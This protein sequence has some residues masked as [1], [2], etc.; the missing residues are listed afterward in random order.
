[1]RLTGL[2]VRGFRN[3]AALEL[4]FPAEGV[5]VVGG[6]GQGKTNLLEAIYYLMLFRS[7]RGAKDRELVRFGEAGFWVAGVAAQEGS[8]EREVG[9]RYELATGRKT[10]V[11]DGMAVEKLADAAGQ[12]LAVPFGPADGEIVFGTPG[13]RRRFLDVVLSVSQPGYLGRLVQMR[14]ALKQRNAALRRGRRDEAR[15]F[16]APLVEAAAFVARCRRSWVEDWAD[17]FGELCAALGEP[18]AADLRYVTQVEESGS[19]AAWRR[20]L[21]KHLDR[22]LRRGA[23]TVG[24]HRDDLR[25]GLGGRDI[26]LYGSAGQRRT[27]AIALRVLEAEALSQARGTSPIGLYDDVFAE[28]D[29]DRQARLLEL[30]RGSLAGQAIVVAPRDAEVPAGLFDRPR[31]RIVGGRIV[32]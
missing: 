20:R 6:N 16:D 23:T 30:L 18:E 32:R 25:I 1:M 24:P 15:A 4:E 29:E 10:A 11:L 26:R 3:L 9:A 12:V 8:R 28:L 5:V 7:L 13:V 21:E 31:W 22:D 19:A 2:S 17:R 14:H 27:A